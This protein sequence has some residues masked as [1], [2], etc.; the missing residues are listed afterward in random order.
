MTVSQSDIAWA[1]QHCADIG[2]WYLGPDPVRAGHHL[3]DPA[4]CA[5]TNDAAWRQW[6]SFTRSYIMVM[7]ASI[8]GHKPAMVETKILHECSPDET[9][10][11]RK[12]L[13]MFWR[14][15]LRQR[16]G[17][18]NVR[19]ISLSGLQHRI[20]EDDVVNRA[21]YRAAAALMDAYVAHTVRTRRAFLDGGAVDLGAIAADTR[22]V[23][24]APRPQL[25]SR[26]QRNLNFDGCLF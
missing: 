7:L 21:V 26:E 3:E 9:L 16:G 13:D 23:T 5:H 20:L 11:A 1:K 19:H 10:G 2:Q 24:D 12:A 14:S 17:V 4:E 8:A 15:G 22:F 6:S 18:R 25:L